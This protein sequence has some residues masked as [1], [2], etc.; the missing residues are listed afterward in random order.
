MHRSFDDGLLKEI[1]RQFFVH[2]LSARLFARLR[3]SAGLGPCP[4]ASLR[5][6]LFR[7]A[8]GGSEEQMRKLLH[9]PQV[10][11]NETDFLSLVPLHQSAEFNLDIGVTKVQSSMQKTKAR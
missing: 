11:V 5:D 9:D 8:I 2:Q 3:R 6:E 10:N 7:I 4:M 1:F